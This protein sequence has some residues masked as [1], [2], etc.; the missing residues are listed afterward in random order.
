MALIN[1][2]QLRDGTIA[3]SK[4]EA[5]AVAWKNPVAVKGLVGNAPVV[6]INALTPTLGD[7]YYVVGSGNITLGNLDVASGDIVEY[8]GT[9]WALIVTNS[10]GFPPAG[11][12]ALLSTQTALV[13]PY[14]DGEDDGQVVVYAASS[15]TATDTGDAIDGNAV[16]VKGDGS[17]FEHS[18]LVFSGA[19]PTGTW[20][21][22][23]DVIAGAGLTKTVDTLAVG[24]AGKGVQVNADDV[25]VDAS[26]IASAS[27]GLQQVT[28]GGN[29]HLLEVKL[30]TTT[31]GGTSGLVKGANGLGVAAGLAGNG[32]TL[33]QGSAMAVD[34]DTETAGNTQAVQVTANGVGL[35]VS[36]IAGTGIEADGSAN[37]RLATQGNGIAGGNGTT[38]SLG[39]ATTITMTGGVWSFT[40]DQLQVTTAPDS[41]N[42][43]VN[44]TYADNLVSGLLWKNP[45][46]GNLLGN[47]D[48]LGLVGNLAAL[49]IEALSPSEG[50]AYVVSTANGAGALTSAVLGDIWQYVSSA[51]VKIVTGSGGFVP[52]GVYALLN[53]TTALVS[54]YTDGVDEGNRVDF[55][56][57]TL[58]GSGL[59]F[60]GT[61][62]D[63][64]VVDGPGAKWEG[65]VR[66]WSGTAWVQLVAAAGGF[67]PAGTRAV[68][69]LTPPFVLISPY[70]DATDD[71]E[72]VSF[73]GASNTGVDTGDAI[74]KAAMLFQDDAHVGFYD[75]SAYV[76]EGT[77]PTGSWVQWNGGSQVN[78]GAGLTKSGNTINVGDAGKGVQVNA[79][80]LE[81]SASEAVAASGGLKAGSNSW[82]LT[83]E[84]ADFAGTGL[85][86]DGADNLRLATQGNGIAGGAG[87]TLSVALDTTTGGGTSGLAVG[88]NGLG[89]AAGLAGNG[90]TLVQGSAMTVDP[91]TETGANT[92]AV[93]VTANGVG[94]LVSDIA[95]TGLEA[96]GSANL[97]LAAQGNG[98]TGGA[99][100]T[101]SV[102]A[103]GTSVSVGASGVKAAVPTTGDKEQQSAATSGDGQTTA[104][105]IA[106]TPAGDGYVQVL[107]NG[108]QVTLG[109]GVKTKDCYFS[110][111]AGST[112]RAITAITAADVLY[113][114][115]V[116]VGFDLETTDYLDFN[117]NVIV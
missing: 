50:D 61:A 22:G 81:F 4:L 65:D 110:A 33:V 76:F 108:I 54:P 44:K 88:A 5:S 60:A 114:N 31:G 79:D 25:Q 101:L 111:D 117:Y 6:G 63:A 67:V 91:D 56:G 38:L 105:T 109:D 40:A 107:L 72:I 97:R 77:T 57:S 20:E 19:V 69:G 48:V 37:L 99:G 78:A 39:T 82:Q 52:A 75:N 2:K 70:V 26:E 30:D 34:P 7:A 62:G 104:I 84:P 94:L 86:D 95:G 9:I 29:E 42:D 17:V 59:M 14:T 53:D 28:G 35:L 58:D 74:D 36:D 66:E 83:I 15:N 85:E 23:G 45:S 18:I 1:G 112:A 100:T 106:A 93:Q 96:D 55:D 8:D 98:I 102:Q 46:V 116:V 41:A 89:V 12:R 71:G 10:G 47:V 73:T 113:W 11:T 115:G 27:G 13:A 16:A 21:G 49:A 24:D 43:P 51:W 103:D 3:A 80:S 68:T 32:L 64:Y 87:S 90:L 92:Q